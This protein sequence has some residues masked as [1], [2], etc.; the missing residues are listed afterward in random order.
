MPS[1]EPPIENAF[2]ELERDLDFIP[3][4]VPHPKVLSQSQIRDYN[5][6]VRGP[7]SA[8]RVAIVQC[9]KLQATHKTVNKTVLQ[10]T[11]ACAVARASSLR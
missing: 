3:L 4:G 9:W 6:L 8:V 2:P 1:A 10:L 7:R 5:E 11:F